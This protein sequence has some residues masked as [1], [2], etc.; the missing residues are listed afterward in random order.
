VA[1]D[2]AGNKGLQAAV[3]SHFSSLGGTIEPIAP[4]SATTVDFSALMISLRLKVQSL[5]AVHGIENVGVYLASFDEGV[6]LMHQAAA[7][8]LL[9]SVH[10][11]GGDGIVM[12]NALLQDSIAAGFAIATGF[13]APTFGLPN[14]PHPDLQEVSGKIKEMTGLNADAFALA[15]Y[16]A[17]WVIA[18]TLAG[19]PEIPDDI[20]SIKNAFV[21]RSENYIGITG[22][23]Y[24]DNNGDRSSGS[25]DYYGI[26]LLDGNYKWKFLGKKT[27]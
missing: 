22:P 17:M 10:W 13:F 7:D 1:R 2:D 11:Y 3:G 12:S 9:A 14:T 25:F 6:L 8:T 4:Y 27:L 20:N 23:A 18:L 26:T 19:Y 15:A 24:L 5:S 16:D 21:T